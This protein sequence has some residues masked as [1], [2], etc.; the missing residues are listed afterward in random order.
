MEF[1]FA[2]I[3]NFCFTNKKKYDTI[4]LLEKEKSGETHS[5]LI[6]REVL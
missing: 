2:V 6:N 5:F 3:G 4:Q 1:K